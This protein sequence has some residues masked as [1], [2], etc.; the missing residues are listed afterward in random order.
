MSW[1]RFMCVAWFVLCVHVNKE[2]GDEDVM[3]EVCV[4]CVLCV[5]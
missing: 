2:A 5:V 1:A 3:A 4:C